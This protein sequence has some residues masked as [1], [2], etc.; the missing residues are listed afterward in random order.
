MT[1]RKA[2]AAPTP[3]APPASVETSTGA[4]LPYVPPAPQPTPTSAGVL[5]QITT[6]ADNQTHDF[7]LVA[8]TLVL[9]MVLGSIPW[10]LV[11]S[12]VAQVWPEHKF[13]AMGVGT[14]IGAICSGFALALGA[15][16]AYR[17]LQST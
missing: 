6:E 3:A 12:L 9:A 16:G 8:M 2:A 11:Q 17:K 15:L 1:K 4:E 13:D 5:K 10:I 7:G 14:A